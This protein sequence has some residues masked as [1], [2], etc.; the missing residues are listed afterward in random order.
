LIAVLKLFNLILIMLK[1]ILEEWNVA[2]NYPI[3]FKHM[4]IA[5]NSYNYKSKLIK[6]SKI[7][8]E[9]K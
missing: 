6:I 4:L 1:L 3:I 8:K 2:N 7:L 9:L 5:K